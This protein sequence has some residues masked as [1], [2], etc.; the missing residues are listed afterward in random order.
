MVLGRLESGRTAFGVGRS[1][2]TRG[3]GRQ[4]TRAAG[5]D[6]F[7]L[8]VWRVRVS[9]RYDLFAPRK[10]RRGKLPEAGRGAR[11]GVAERI[12]QAEGRQGQRRRGHPVAGPRRRSTRTPGEEGRSRRRFLVPGRRIQKSTRGWGAREGEFSG[13]GYKIRIQRARYENRGRDRARSGC[14]CREIEAIGR[15]VAGCVDDVV[16]DQEARVAP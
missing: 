4:S 15:S 9:V 6:P 10:H 12:P 14:G 7:A 3:A 16:G 5:A 2:Q 13:S 1:R 8:R 11:M